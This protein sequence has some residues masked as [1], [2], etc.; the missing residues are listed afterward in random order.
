MG[1]LFKYFDC[2]SGLGLPGVL[3]QNNNGISKIEDDFFSYKVWRWAVQGR[4]APREYPDLGL[5]RAGK[6]TMCDI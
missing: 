4:Y 2:V 6:Y 3:P 1:E 5:L